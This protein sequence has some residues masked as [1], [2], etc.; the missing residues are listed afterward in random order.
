MVNL[1]KGIIVRK[2]K[3]VDF[4]QKCCFHRIINRAVAGF[5]EAISTD[6]QKSSTVVPGSA[7]FLAVVI[8]TGVVKWHFVE[9]CS[10]A[11]F[12]REGRE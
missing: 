4:L 2:I 11:S 6:D 3:L 12:P 9:N 7:P 8:V 1:S 10:S 5:K